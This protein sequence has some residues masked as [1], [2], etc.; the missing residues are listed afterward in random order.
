MIEFNVL[1][2]KTE[3]DDMYT[4]FLLKKNVWVDIIK[5]ILGYPL[6]AAPNIL[7]EWKVAITLVEQGYKSTESWNNYKTSTGTT[8]G[9][10]RAPIDIGKAQDSFDENGRP[11]C[12]NYNA[13]GHITREC[14][15]LKKEKETRKCYKC[16]KVGH[17]A[18]DY[19]SK[20]KMKIRRNQE[21]ADG[22][23]KEEN[24]NKKGFVEGLE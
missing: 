20:Q 22:S 16:D 17:L 4:I 18:K 7:K 9:G 2:M 13:Y 3:T 19:R 10:Q 12:F 1:A 15:K 24:N 14:R 5:T 11:R 6:M 21:E 23:D 8:F